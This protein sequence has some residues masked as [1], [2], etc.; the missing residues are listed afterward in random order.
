MA[1]SERGLPRHGKIG[2]NFNIWPSGIRAVLSRGSVSARGNRTGAARVAARRND[3]ASSAPCWLPRFTMNFRYDLEGSLLA[4]EPDYRLRYTNVIADVSRIRIAN[5]LSANAR[6]PPWDR[7]DNVTCTQQKGP[8][9]RD[10]P[11]EKYSA[12]ACPD[13]SS[14]LDADNLRFSW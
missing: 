4:P 11:R 2:A 8:R 5:S 3:R 9:Q 1:P 6:T 7:L 10:A 12:V 13:P 14:G